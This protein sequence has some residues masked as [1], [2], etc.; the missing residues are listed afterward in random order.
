[1]A[2]VNRDLPNMF[3]EVFHVHSFLRDGG[4]C[5]GLGELNS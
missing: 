5:D 3:N 4:T 2:I 1:M